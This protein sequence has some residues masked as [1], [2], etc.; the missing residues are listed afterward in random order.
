[1]VPFRGQRLGAVE[2]M[3]SITRTEAAEKKVRQYAVSP[4]MP[5]RTDREVDLLNAKRQL[6]FSPLHVGLPGFFVS[7]GRLLCLCSG[8]I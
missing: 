4:L 5:D 7:L 3:F 1:M 6:C 8:A 2:P